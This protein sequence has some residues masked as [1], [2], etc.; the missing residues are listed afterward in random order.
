MPSHQQRREPLPATYQFGDMRPRVE[1][2]VVVTQAV[3]SYL[4]GLHLREWNNRALY[5]VDCPTGYIISL[6]VCDM[7][8]VRGDE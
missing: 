4:I 5:S 2:R 7:T 3:F 6:D 8:F 1:K